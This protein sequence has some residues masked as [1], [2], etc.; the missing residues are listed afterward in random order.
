MIGAD[1]LWCCVA[2]RR[3][4]LGTVNIERGA[5]NNNATRRVCV[6]PRRRP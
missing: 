3:V 6:E 4:A 5:G 1:V 2:L